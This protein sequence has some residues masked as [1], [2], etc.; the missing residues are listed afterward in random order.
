[1]EDITEGDETMTIS[2]CIMARDEA[3]LVNDCLASVVPNVDEVIFFD[4]GSVDF[5]V[6]IAASFGEKVKI[7]HESWGDDFG[8]MRTKTLEKA[9]GD[10]ILVID[11]DERIADV[12]KFKEL[13]EYLPRE[14]PN[15]VGYKVGISNDVYDGTV[16]EDKQVRIF[17]NRMGFRYINP[18]HNQLLIRGG[19]ADISG[20][21]KFRHLGYNLS[22]ER[23]RE[24]YLARILIL[25][26]EKAKDLKNPMTRLFLS[27]MYI[28]GKEYDLA[29]KEAEEGIEILKGIQGF[30]FKGTPFMELFDVLKIERREADGRKSGNLG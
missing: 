5:T 15:V 28:Q 11:A 4:T 19:I 25:E 7:F 3:N 2:A 1:M 9:S 22:P 23:M 14:K 18:I 12:E 27:K 10:W 13:V 21:V 8:G 26:K 30:E 20:V 29:K 6:E 17:R 16:V 24:K